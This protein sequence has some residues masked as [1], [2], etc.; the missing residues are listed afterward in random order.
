LT[1]GVT[2]PGPATADTLTNGTHIEVASSF[3][4]PES[5]HV[6]AGVATRLL[7]LIR[8][9]PMQQHRAHGPVGDGAEV[10]SGR[11]KVLAID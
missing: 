11:R 3:T 7:L 4:K 2:D 8:G 5:C 10:W 6:L 1:A 9:E